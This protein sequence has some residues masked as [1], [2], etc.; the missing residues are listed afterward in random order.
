LKGQGEVFGGLGNAYADMGNFKKAIDCYEQALNIARRIK[1][2][3]GEANALGNLSIIWSDLGDLDK[4]LTLAR[5]AL[6]IFLGIESPYAQQAGIYLTLVE[7]RHGISKNQ[8]IELLTMQNFVRGA[9]QSLRL[10]SPHAAQFFNVATKM[11]AD[12]KL[13]P[14]LQEL[15]KVMR[16]LLVGVQSLDLSKLPDELAILIEEEMKKQ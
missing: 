12:I 14:V 9:I 8:E 7:V 15:A 5:Q 11:A 10:N 6:Q 4:A 16:K 2:P 3:R 13:S 1:D